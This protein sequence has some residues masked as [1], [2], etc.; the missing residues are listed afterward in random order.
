MII[1]A[2]EAPVA[3]EEIPTPTH[4]PSDRP[5]VRAVPT[6]H[7][8]IAGD[9]PFGSVE[10]RTQD[11]TL[12]AADGSVVFSQPGVE[13]P[14]T[15]TPQAVR[16]VAGKYFRGALKSPERETSIRQLIGR[17]ADTITR[18]GSDSGMLGDSEESLTF[19][20]EL[21][22]LLLHQRAAFNSP[23]W[24]N[25]GVEEEAQ[26][27]ACFINSVDDTMESILNLNRT[28]GMLFKHGSGSGVNLSTLRSS[29]ENLAGGGTASG[30]VSFMRGLDA[31]AGAI[32]SGG[33]TRRAAKMVL[34][35]VDHPD[36]FDFVHCKEVE[37]AK[38][39]A[40]VAAGYDASFDS[41]GGAYDS[42]AF[43]NANHSIRVSDEFMHAVADDSAWT[44]HAVTD[45]AEVETFPARHLLS[46]VAEAAWVCGD[47]G[48]QFHDTINRWHT[49]PVDG[50]ITGSNP[51][52]EFVFLD[53]TA[54]NLASINLLAFWTEEEGFD[55]AGFEQAVR[56][57][58]TAQE[59]LI[60][61]AAYPTTK[62]RERSRRY[63]PLGL[64]FS[65]LGSLL[66]ANALPYDSEKARR[67]AASI[68]ALM[69]AI[70]YK[71][72][73]LLAA[74][75]GPFDRFAANRSAMLGVLERHLEAADGLAEGGAVS[76][77]IEA[78]CR[79]WREAIDLGA[80]FGFRHSQV[81][82]LAPTGTISFM[83]DCETT[84]I[85]PE[86]A[87]VKHKWLVGGGLMV[88]TN[89]LVPSV[90][91][92][93][94][95]DSDQ[96]G[97]ILGH[98]EATGSIE[99]APGL[100]PDH[101]AVFDCAIG[102]GEGRSIEPKGHVDMMAVVQPFISG[103]IS[104]TVNLPHEV[105][106]DG[107]EAIY[108]EAWEKGLKSI[109]VYRD[110]CKGSQPIGVGDGS[111]T[112]DAATATGPTTLRRRLPDERQSVTHKFSIGDHEGYLTV[113]MYDDGQPGEIFLVMA[114]EGSTISGLMDAFATAISIALQYGVPLPALVEK[115]SH[116]R[117]E[118][119]GFTRNRRIPYAKS[120]T[121]YI[122]RWLASR[123][124]EEDA[125][126]AAGVLPSPSTSPLAASQRGEIAE[127]GGSQQDAPACST[128]GDLMMRSG[129]CYTC[130]G[131][132]ATSGCG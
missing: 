82:A 129:S 1:E 115:F 121:D 4:E 13:A 21:V 116:T 81:T 55:V 89:R 15:W 92:S 43:Q 74:V 16:V 8:T 84:G 66:L 19:H 56:V 85:E 38:A 59:I 17:V 32:K 5:G 10:W 73:A 90:L 76:P 33:K 126:K 109:A 58:I 86:M 27:S 123:F 2:N 14:T 6:R 71:Q 88:Q 39:Q 78:G 83:M 34:L 3:T 113:G 23:V 128:C 93:L 106:P 72:S 29:R 87:L 108:R 67:L 130:P 102:V 75:H 114:K 50:A 40:L 63:R 25:V 18:W 64:G 132:G 28:E 51:C 61:R 110:G 118:P 44:T 124:L 24:F 41:V 131:C 49:C 31:F 57:L 46:A 112:V 105:T 77:L 54:C 7:F 99:G 20:D 11:V 100:S 69:T 68:A 53:D 47:P 120:V 52:S 22:Y 94:G 107:I 101:L 127:R 70:A 79:A 96:V 98:L 119:A 30:P 104:K 42:V 122:F 125:C 97:A 36:I 103:A 80:A 48:I 117:Y 37:E 45:G 65:N 9:D 111:P 26:C 60:D 35:D 62:I 95:Y 91:R 12:T